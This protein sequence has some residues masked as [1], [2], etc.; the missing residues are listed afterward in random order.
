VAPLLLAVGGVGYATIDVVG[1]T[2]LQRV[3]DERRLA[4]LLGALEGIGLVGL[5]IGSAAAPALIL[6]IGV[7]PATIAIGLVMPVVVAVSWVG[8]RRIDRK[9][10]IPV[11]ELA[12]L[13]RNAVLSLLPG[14]QLETAARRTRWVTLE[15]GE[16]LIREGD[17]GDRYYVLA[18]GTL[19]VS[20]ADRHLRDAVEE[21]EGLG[22]IALLRDVPRTATVTAL[23]PVVTLALERAD[24]LQAVT[25]HQQAYDAGRRIAGERASGSA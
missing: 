24:F 5:A 13:R 25:G 16:T 17:H 3:T 11:R 8:L 2:I 23:T 21:G 4:L 10:N 19:R 20:A 12:L 1:R 14:P 18:S 7:G 15:A 6:A 22:E 9:A